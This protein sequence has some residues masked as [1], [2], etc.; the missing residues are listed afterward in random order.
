MGHLMK[1]HE[2]HVA[3]YEFRPLLNVFWREPF[4]SWIAFAE[5][6]DSGVDPGLKV[7]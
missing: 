7:S 2:Q 6:F 5:R 4:E 3:G 1:Q